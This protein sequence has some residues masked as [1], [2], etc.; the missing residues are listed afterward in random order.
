MLQDPV[1]QDLLLDEHLPRRT[2]PLG[3]G[4]VTSSVDQVRDALRSISEDPSLDAALRHATVGACGALAKARELLRAMP[5]RV[6]FG[7]RAMQRIL[8][9]VVDTLSSLPPG[10]AAVVPICWLRPLGTAASL[11]EYDEL[12]RQLKVA[13]RGGGVHDFTTCVAASAKSAARPIAESAANAAKSLAREAV[14]SAVKAKFGD[15]GVSLLDGA[16]PPSGSGVGA[17]GA[18][19]PSGG[20][21]TQV[22]VDPGQNFVLCVA[23]RD[24]GGDSFTVSIVNGREG[25][26]TGAEYHPSRPCAALSGG[27]AAAVPLF[28]RLRTIELRDVPR[29]NI[30]DPA[31]WLAALRTQYFPC[32][33]GAPNSGPRALYETLL[34]ALNARPLATNGD[35]SRLDAVWEAP[36]VAG[37][38]SGVRS[39]VSALVP[40]LCGLG[41]SVAASRLVAEVLVPLSFARRVQSALA[42]DPAL[43]VA[44][45]AA[46]TGAAAAVLNLGARTA[47]L[48][49]S[50]DDGGITPAQCDSVRVCCTALRAQVENAKCAEWSACLPSSVTDATARRLAHPD[51]AL[52]ARFGRFRIDDAGVNGIML[53]GTMAPPRILRPI[54]LTLVMNHGEVR[55]MDEAA[56]AMRHAV[57]LCELL[58][59]QHDIVP[60]SCRLRVALVQHLVTR[61][62]PLPLPVTHAERDRRCFWTAEPLQRG[63][64]DEIVRLLHSITHH[65]VAASLALTANASFN[66]ARI[67][68]LASI[69][70]LTDAVVRRLASDHASA[71]SKHYSGE[72]EGPTRPFAIAIGPRLRALSMHMTLVSPELATARSSV[73]DYFDS[74]HAKVRDDHVIFD[75]SNE[76]IELGEGDARLVNQLCID[77]GLHQGQRGSERATLALRYLTGEDRSLIDSEPTFGLF[78]DIAFV[79]QLLMCGGGGVPTQRWS[80]KDALLM[81]C[82]ASAAIPL[83]GSGVSGRYENPCA[84]V[85][86]FGGRVITCTQQAAHDGAAESSGSPLSWFKKKLGGRKKRRVVDISSDPTILVPGP[87]RENRRI[88]TEE[89]V[90][91][92]KGSLRTLPFNI[93]DNGD[94][95]A[96]PMLSEPDVELLLQ[97]LTAPLLRIPLAAAF[98]ADA[99][100][101]NVLV[102]PDLQALLDAILFDPG[103]HRQDAKHASLH[104]PTQLPAEDRSYLAT[105]CGLLFQELA[106]SP[107]MLCSSLR[108]MLTHMVQADTGHW[109]DEH[110]ETMLYIIRLVVR[111]E[112]YVLTII[113]HHDWCKAGEPEEEDAAHSKRRTPRRRTTRWDAG[114]DAPGQFAQSSWSSLARGIQANEATVATLRAWQLETRACLEDEVL[115]A[116]ELWCD[117]AMAGDDEATKD[118]GVACKLWAHMAF[119]FK[120]IDTGAPAVPRGVAGGSDFSRLARMSYTAASTMVVAMT[121]LS[122]RHPVGIEQEPGAS[123]L[124]GLPETEVFQLWQ[125]HRR[126][127]KEWLNE[128]ELQASEIMEAVIR[129]VSHTNG[130]K[131]PRPGAAASDRV[132]HDMERMRPPI[133]SGGRFLPNTEMLR[134]KSRIAD[135]VDEAARCV[136]DAN[137]DVDGE[138]YETWLRKITTLAVET[139]INVQLGNLTLRRN[140][141]QVL[142]EYVSNHLDFRSAMTARASEGSV[143]ITCVMKEARTHCT[144][145][146]LVGLWHDVRIWD[147]D[148]DYTARIT[149]A[150][151]HLAGRV[152][153]GDVASVAPS[154][155]WVVGALAPFIDSLNGP[156]PLKDVQL[157]M[158]R[159]TID[160]N[161]LE[162]TLW[163]Q[164]GSTMKEIVVMRHMCEAAMPNS[165]P[166]APVVLVYN[167]VQHG[168]R[169]YRTLVFVSDARFSYADSGQRSAPC[170]WTAAIGRGGGPALVAQV[171]VGNARAEATPPVCSVI[172]ARE[173]SR[174]MGRQVFM[175]RRFLRGLLPAVLVDANQWWQ[176]VEPGNAS[177]P[178]CGAYGPV[179]VGSLVGYNTSGAGG[180]DDD[181]SGP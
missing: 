61:T 125:T 133:N 111:V 37:D 53:A 124:L 60:N 62:L 135:A 139:E 116:I 70:T 50:P 131:R 108:M 91:H 143:G 86:A 112:E 120:A 154:A 1:L 119:I 115:P 104:F 48:V 16:L 12:Q 9:D 142:E 126:C 22:A 132:W 147:A 179:P 97:F 103:A 58:D 96:F 177:V 57:E 23:V 77:R 156:G 166:T 74:L 162:V 138:A 75:Y 25:S 88:T 121:F 13:I 92:I 55:N 52:H 123:P 36:A 127:L 158:P 149:R 90:L 32:A 26:D 106:K 28:E 49:E 81:W 67:L 110:G 72:S 14:K 160:P 21:P 30:C 19:N 38:A 153:N 98:F 47:A 68:T 163:G 94:G 117:R 85:V 76:K 105:P 20:S 46:I 180:D 136:V 31:W 40:L 144:W 159:E 65:Y 161:A 172:V 128:N 82:T 3:L 15:F 34:P 5:P 173:L 43:L 6:D 122:A 41:A 134:T 178:R 181:T 39:V 164:L 170:V 56:L 171:P 146:S 141:L 29:R 71:L 165:V 33:P 27:S 7:A 64:Q 87:M 114:G 101:I 99:I 145:K 107:A 175:P 59:N 42:A 73:L 10:G 167:V 169:F 130:G 168:R 18:A 95:V 35:R 17:G 118:Y 109:R 89:D 93:Y 157:R 78:R 148:P 155:A 11:D 45:T 83:P 79:L 44:N 51:A 63:M 100:R 174:N 151:D 24:A 140:Q 152:F 8:S 66:A 84:R 129:V 137:G 150:V 176:Q 4:F 69:A 54:E 80:K 113:R 102:S 2:S